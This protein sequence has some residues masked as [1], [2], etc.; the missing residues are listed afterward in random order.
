MAEGKTLLTWEVKKEKKD[1][2]ALIYIGI[3]L[4]IAIAAAIY[5]FW[6]KDYYTAPVFVVLALVL[7]WY[8][9]SAPKSALIAI[10]A[11]GFKI[12]NR[13]YKFESFKSYWI[14]E[15]SGI[16]YFEHKGRIGSTVSFPSGTKSPEEIKQYIPEDIIE[17]EDKG[18]DLTNRIADI[19]KI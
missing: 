18:D 3:V 8:F 2:N 13:F 4:I 10:T 11:D 19:F 12:D 14:S 7:L 15:R 6:Q 1:N 5:Y 17:T 16:F 9:F